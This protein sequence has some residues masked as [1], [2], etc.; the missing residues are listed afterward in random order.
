MSTTGDTFGERVGELAINPFAKREHLPANAKRGRDHHS[1]TKVAPG[2]KLIKANQCQS[3]TKEH[4]LRKANSMTIHRMPI[5]KAR[6][7]LGAVAKRVRNDGEYFIL[8]K[9]GIPVMG[10]MAPD[11]LEDYLD[12][13][14]PAVKSAIKKSRADFEAGRFRPASE[15]QAELDALTA[16]PRKRTKHK[17]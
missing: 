10:I 17:V 5:T 11:E 9:D 14:D 16:K 13:R 2:S 8:E 1:L 6:I 15:L 4:S 7:N 3:L 12:A